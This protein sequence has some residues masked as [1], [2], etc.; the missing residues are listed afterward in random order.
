MMEEGRQG[1]RPLEVR[2]WRQILNAE[3]GR[4]RKA[5]G[6]YSSM[7]KAEKEGKA[8]GR[9]RLEVGSGDFRMEEGR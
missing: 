5:E 2:G 3:G 8:C 6:K 7:L 4:R 9:W 1:L